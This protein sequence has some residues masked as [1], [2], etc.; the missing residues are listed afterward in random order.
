MSVH[1]RK[2]QN[3]DVHEHDYNSNDE[4]DEENISQC[5]SVKHVTDAA[6]REGK[7]SKRCQ[8][9]CDGFSDYITSAS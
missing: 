8:V 2:R 3:C 6:V 1:K 5:R 9:V 4:V 7:R